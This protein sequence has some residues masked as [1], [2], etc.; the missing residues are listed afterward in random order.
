MV[1]DTPNRCIFCSRV[2]ESAGPLGFEAIEEPIWVCEVCISRLAEAQS[3]RDKTF[4]DVLIE[5]VAA[6][7]RRPE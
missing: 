7:D 6:L 4:I 5:D 2:A 3:S 1:S